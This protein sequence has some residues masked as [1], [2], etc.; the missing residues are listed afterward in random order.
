MTTRSTLASLGLGLLVLHAA[1]YSAC[2][3]VATLTCDRAADSCVLNDGT[4]LHSAPTQRFPLSTVVSARENE[5]ISKDTD[6]AE[7]HSRRLEIVTRTGVMLFNDAGS[8]AWQPSLMTAD[9]INAFLAHADQPTLVATQDNR[10]KFMLATG[11]VLWGMPVSMALLVL[12][13][14]LQG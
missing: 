1:L 14:R 10:L 3:N 11:V 7:V 9:R 8:L 13:R 4:L 6:G 12:I 2:A 5:T